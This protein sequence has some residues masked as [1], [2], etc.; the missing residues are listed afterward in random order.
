MMYKDPDFD[1]TEEDYA[2]AQRNGIPR[3]VAYKRFYDYGWDKLDAIS[4][5]RRKHRKFQYDPEMVKLAKKN[6]IPLVIFRDR[7]TTLGWTEEQAATI[8]V[9]TREDVGQWNAKINS[10]FTQE[11]IETFTRNGIPRGTVRGRLLRGWSM[12]EAISVPVLK[13]GERLKK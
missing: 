11:Q 10:K 8:P 1:L 3:D 7:V 12:A 4:R 6:D 2:E 13:A 9:M 5:P